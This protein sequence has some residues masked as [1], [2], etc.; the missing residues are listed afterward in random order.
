MTPLKAIENMQ[1][2]HGVLSE[3]YP[4][5]KVCAN[6]EC[7]KP[8]ESTHH[9][10]GRPPGPNSSSWF[11]YIGDPA[12]KNDREIAKRAIPHG[13]GLCGHGTKDCHGDVEAHRAWIKYEDGVF[14]WY[15]RMGDEGESTITW[16]GLGPL[17]PQPFAWGDKKKKRPR[18]KGD[19]KRK[20]RTKTFRFPDDAEDGRGQV[21][22]GL[23]ELERKLGYDP[24][25]SEGYR[26][27]DAVHFANA[28]VDDEIRKVVTSGDA[29]DE[30]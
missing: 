12:G 9:I 13:I 25:R 22:D 16:H 27:M 17:D 21:E 24:P 1:D 28:W 4:R 14:V 18:K 6:P 8:T 10:F 20:T 2:V 30:C 7:D 19:E 26:L 15:E 29:A 23:E 11:V 5:N 3:R